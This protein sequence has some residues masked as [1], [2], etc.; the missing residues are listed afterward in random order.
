[1]I[2]IIIIIII[3]SRKSFA[4]MHVFSWIIWLYK[5]KALFHIQLRL[6]QK[7]WKV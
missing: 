6:L 7:I 3:A 2:I 1:M 5:D 4:R